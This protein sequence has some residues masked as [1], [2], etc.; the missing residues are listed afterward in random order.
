MDVAEVPS[1]EH[2]GSGGA[3][4][5]IIHNAESLLLAMQAILC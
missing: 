2:S 3:T 5:C 1:A 4:A